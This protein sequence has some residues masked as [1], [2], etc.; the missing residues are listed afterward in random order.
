MPSSQ[1]M[2]FFLSSALVTAISV[3]LL[4]YG[5]SAQW[6]TT[7]MECASDGSGFFN[8]TAIITLDLFKGNLAR[9]FCPLFGS[10]DNFQGNAS[11]VVK[12]ELFIQNTFL[13]TLPLDRKMF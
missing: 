4:G 12:W 9:N 13:L 8:G 7:T 10:N 1:K 11:K 6:A 3:G 5:M 2:L